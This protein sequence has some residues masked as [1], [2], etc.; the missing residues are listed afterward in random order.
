MMLSRFSKYGMGA[1]L[2]VAGVLSF[3]SCATERQPPSGGGYATCQEQLAAT[4]CRLIGAYC[5][6]CA[7]DKTQWSP[8]QC[9]GSTGMCWCV[10]PATGVATGAMV[11]G[12]PTCVVSNE[13]PATGCMAERAKPGYCTAPGAPCPQCNQIDPTK[14]NVKQCHGSTATCK[15]V[16]PSTGQETADQSCLN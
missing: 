7:E 10:N 1:I 14:W 6:Q 8:V 12:T 13:P 4:N 5:P 15:C 16:N 3:S 9:W 2:I 11:R